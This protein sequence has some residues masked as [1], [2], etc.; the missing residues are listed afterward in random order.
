M[1]A[2][3]LPPVDTVPLI[4]H[5]TRHC[6]GGWPRLRHR[7]HAATALV[8]VAGVAMSSVTPQASAAEVSF[9]FS[10]ELN[11]VHDGGN[12]GFA[13]LFGIGDTLSGS[14]TYDTDLAPYYQ[15]TDAY[16]TY[17]SFDFLSAPALT[18]S[19][20]VSE[21]SHTFQLESGNVGIYTDGSGDSFDVSSVMEN[22]ASLQNEQINVGL[23]LGDWDGGMLSTTDTLPSDIDFNLVD[24]GEFYVYGSETEAY[25]EITAFFLDIGND[26][27]P[28][29][30]PDGNLIM[31]ATQPEFFTLE[32]AEL[33]QT[34]KTTVGLFEDSTFVQEGGTHT[35]AE[36]LV[37]GDANEFVTGEGSYLLQG[38][39]LNS[40]FAQV[41]PYGEGSF[42]QTG[43]T[44]NAESIMIGNVGQEGAFSGPVAIG[45]GE[46]AMTGGDL[47]VG[48]SGMSVGGHGRG[49]FSQSGGDVVIG[50]SSIHNPNLG[51][52][53]IG[54]GTSQYDP[55][56]FV[57]DPAIQRRGSYTLG[58][59]TLTV[60]GTTVL[61]GGSDFSGHNYGGR[62][63]FNQSG[64]TVFIRNDLVV[65]EAGN[66]ASGEGQY[67]ISGGALNVGGDLRV[68][69]NYGGGNAAE[70][71]F[72][73]TGGNVDVDG[74]I[75][76]GASATILPNGYTIRGGSTTADRV[77]V[78]FGGTAPGQA[79]LEVSNGGLLT[80]DVFVNGNGVLTGDG[81]TIDGAVTLNGGTLAP[82][83]SPGTLS[84]LGDLFLI[85]G[86][87][88]LEVGPGLFDQ[89][90]VGGNLLL[91]DDLL[92]DLI[93]DTAP[94]E[95]GFDLTGLF[96][97]AGDMT[98]GG[99]FSLADSL[100]IA[101]L[102]AGTSL[103]ITLSDQ[104]LTYTASAVPVPAAA[105]LFGSGILGLVAVARRRP[106]RSAA[107]I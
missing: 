9:Q 52:L 54:M 8:L 47:N 10:A 44:H 6:A 86:R 79:V 97:V 25:A 34:N 76:I 82:G 93:F 102:E 55:D 92:I 23:Y 105:W 71:L 3:I 101:G 51:Q 70:G 38:G 85:D 90:I 28:T 78:G 91:G 49:D 65:G 32:A 40:G 63:E 11:F 46:Y 89:L 45:I 95:T 20:F 29:V 35:T 2:F 73:Q 14:L 1:H 42:I 72:F 4:P 62:G 37:G 67:V 80:G 21:L 39:T 57:I 43:G 56:D 50:S 30:D 69:D 75:V 22:V 27:E 64:G 81:G 99:G 41:G 68:A 106:G 7:R 94:A 17:S 84:V 60:Y 104:Q 24:Y 36:L 103:L 13:A 5:R 61:G 58:D 98:F 107:S 33:L 53:R 74:N 15:D 83:N 100:S 16:G 66:A 88:Q 59:G 31:G 18:S 19:L 77:E 96:D 12:S 48:L 87:L 26:Q